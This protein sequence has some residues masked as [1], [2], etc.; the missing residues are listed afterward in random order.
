MDHRSELA[1]L[2]DD[3]ETAFGRALGALFRHKAD[4]MRPGL[5]RHAEHLLGRGHLEI[6][7]PVEFCLEPRDVVIANVAAILAQMRRNSVTTGRDCDLRR[8]HGIGMT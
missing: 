8:A 5:K 3:V 4:S 7:R 2:P 6:E 1:A